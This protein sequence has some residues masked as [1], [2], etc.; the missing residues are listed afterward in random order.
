MWSHA[1]CIGVF[2]TLL[3]RNSIYGYVENDPAADRG[4]EQAEG[5]FVLN[6]KDG[7]VSVG[8]KKD[9]WPAALRKHG[10]GEEP[11][12]ERPSRSFRLSN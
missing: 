12:V 3:L 5:F 8:L 2:L 4:Y 11:G 9:E 7:A 1:A 6:T 10:I